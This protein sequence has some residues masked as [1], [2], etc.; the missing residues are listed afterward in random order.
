MAE[1]FNFFSFFFNAILHILI[2]RSCQDFVQQ[3]YLIF[4]NLMRIRKFENVELLEFNSYLT[5][6][7]Y[8][9]ELSLY[10]WLFVSTLIWSGSDL[11]VVTQFLI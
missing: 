11:K 5:Y 10:L 7:C 8:L 6:T 1:L 3:F 2:F 4:A 9:V